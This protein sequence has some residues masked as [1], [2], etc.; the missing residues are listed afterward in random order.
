MFLQL[1][2]IDKFKDRHVRSAQIY[3]W[4]LASFVGFLPTQNA[5]APTIAS[6]ESRELVHWIGSRKVVSPCLGKR[7]EFFRHFGA[8]R[9]KADVF[10]AGVATT[11]A[12]EARHWVRTA[13][14]QA[15]AKNIL[16]A[17]HIRFPLKYLRRILD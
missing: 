5:Q 8:E 1:F 9:V 10:W 12:K 17:V 6:F 2:K 3:A 7:Q 4:G 15:G 16:S 11:I 13:F 14:F